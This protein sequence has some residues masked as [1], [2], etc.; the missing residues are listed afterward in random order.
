MYKD[1]NENMNNS[2]NEDP[3]DTKKQLNELMKRVQDLKAQ[4]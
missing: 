4:I 2:L 3:E 1:L